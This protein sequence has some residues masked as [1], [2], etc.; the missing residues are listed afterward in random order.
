MMTGQEEQYR[1]NEYEKVPQSVAM[2]NLK[3]EIVHYPLVV[4]G[5]FESV[6]VV[7]GK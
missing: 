4:V 1:E 6:A 2:R 3:H 5:L 7:D